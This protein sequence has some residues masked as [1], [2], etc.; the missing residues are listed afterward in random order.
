MRVLAGSGELR[1]DGPFVEPGHRD[2]PADQ[3]QFHLP[4]DIAVDGKGNVVVADSGNHMIRRITPSGVVETVAGSG[5][6][7]VRDGP[8]REAQFRVPVSVAVGPDGTIY[9]VDSKASMVRA[10][11]TD[12]HVRTVAGTDFDACNPQPDK[13]ATSD[14]APTPTGC[15]EPYTQPY[16]DRPGDQALLDEPSAVAV[17]PDGDLDVSDGDNHC[18]R[19]IDR[20]GIV[21]TYAGTC[22]PGYADGPATLAQFTT[23]GDLVVDSEGSVIV[24]DA[25]SRLRKI[26]PAGIVST[27]AGS[28]GRGYRD[29]PAQDALLGRI[30]GITLAPNGDLVFADVLNGRLRVLAQSGQVETL[31]GTGGQGLKTGSALSATFSYPAG[32]ALRGASIL[33]ADA[34]TMRIFAI[35]ER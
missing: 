5:E 10:I 8:A 19:R 24:V 15:A 2:G 35:S 22:S 14:S 29:G 34:N 9:V 6:E 3:A 33:L 4:F 1:E 13:N 16:R 31:A 20:D 7:G 32:V 28:D 25:G 18:I 26:T 23:P 17:G 11:G 27:I 21:S 12:G 30:T